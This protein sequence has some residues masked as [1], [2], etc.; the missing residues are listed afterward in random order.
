MNGAVRYWRNLGGGQF[1]L[2]RTM[3]T[4]PPGSGL[5]DPGVQLADMNGNGR[6]DLLVRA[7]ATAITRSPSRGSGTS[8][9]SCATASAPTRQPRRRRRAARRPR[10]RRGDRRAP[11]RRELRA[12]LQRPDHAAGTGVETRPRRPRAEFPE[13]Q[14]LRPARQARGPDRRRPAGHRPRPPGPHRVLAL[15]G[16]RPLGP[17]RHDAQQPA[18]SPT[19]LLPRRSASTPSGS[20]SATWTAT[21]WPISSMSRRT[22]SRS[23]ST[24]AATR[25]SDP[26]AI[27][28]TPPVT[29]VDAVRLA[30]MLGTGTD[31]ILWTYDFGALAATA[32][33][34]SS[35]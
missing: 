10:R 31:G 8:G 3:A 24:R 2:P 21:A 25:W 1:D 7:A 33:T 32:L 11:H 35:T 30:D 34:S 20:C 14:L 22:A 26:I 16:P 12:L 27:H 6:A 13:R 29:D 15:S 9:A 17:P 19:H 5:S 18:C 28:G 23:G 4:A